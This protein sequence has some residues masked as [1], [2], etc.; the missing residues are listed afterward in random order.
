M[1][2]ELLGCR[3]TATLLPPC[4]RYTQDGLRGLS[5]LKSADRAA[6]TMLLPLVQEGLLDVH[7]GLVERFE[8]GAA[9][10][11]DSSWD[12]RRRYGW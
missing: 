11:D 8:E 6:A 1:P 7:L 3:P 10:E 5:S 9:E 12:M 2:V 4:R